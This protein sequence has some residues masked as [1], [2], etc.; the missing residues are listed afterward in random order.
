M[1]RLKRKQSASNP[2]SRKKMKTETTA[3]QLPKKRPIPPC[4]RLL[5]NDQ[6]SPTHPKI[7]SAT[8]HEWTSDQLRVLYAVCEGQNV[9]FTG[10]AGTGKSAL[11]NHIR[12]VLLADQQHVYITAPTGVAATVIGGTTIHS[13]AG[14]GIGGSVD[15]LLKITRSRP[16]SIDRWKQTRTL[17]IDEISM[18][19][20]ELFDSLERIAREVRSIPLYGE[21]AINGPPFGGI[22]LIVCG[23]FFQLPPV[24]AVRFAFQADSWKSCFPLENQIELTTVFRQSDKEFITLLNDIRHAKMSQ[25]T[26][27]TLLTKVKQGKPTDQ[28]KPTEAKIVRTRLYSHRA[29]AEEENIKELD[30]LP[31]DLMTIE[32]RDHGSDVRVLSHLPVPQDLYLKLN[33]QVMLL[34]N[35]DVGSK[36]VNGSRGVVVNFVA[37]DDPFFPILPMVEFSTG[38]IRTMFP[39]EWSIKMGNHTVATRLQVPLQLGWA[40]TIHK[41]QGCTLEEAELSLGDCF[42]KGQVYVALSRLRSLDRAWIKSFDPTK[43]KTD[44]NVVEFYNQINRKRQLVEQVCDDHLIRVLANLVMEY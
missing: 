38:E 17:I 43:V 7:K 2:S 31:A 19:D 11:L 3:S 37:N 4:H 24:K 21:S 41:S 22:Q 42:E 13:F 25:R 32:A 27:Q 39:V 26:I 18:M 12:T 10:C 1:K 9:F 15:H 16:D 6:L 5:P 29:E 30:R 35:L 20:G 33:A 40:I 28:G 14:I 23:D 8:Q 36:L 34:R 44:A